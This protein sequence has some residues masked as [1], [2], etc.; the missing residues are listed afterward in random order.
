MVG[1]ENKT[2]GNAIEIPYSGEFY[3]VVYDKNII[4]VLIF[5]FPTVLIYFIIANI[6]ICGENSPTHPRPR[7]RDYEIVSDREHYSILLKRIHFCRLS[8]FFVL[9]TTE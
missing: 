5:F 9:L 4:D 3:L 8:I 2:I 7:A 6:T 1:K